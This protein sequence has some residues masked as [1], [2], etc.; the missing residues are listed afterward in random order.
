M[1]AKGTADTSLVK[2]PHA[3]FEY[4][5]ETLREVKKWGYIHS[6]AL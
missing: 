1:A 6:G 2:Q 3:Q 5:T 4:D